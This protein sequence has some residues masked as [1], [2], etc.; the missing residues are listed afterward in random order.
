LSIIRSCGRGDYEA[1]YDTGVQ[2][3]NGSLEQRKAF[4]GLLEKWDVV[5]KELKEEQLKL[6]RNSRLVFLPDCGHNVQL[7]RPDVVASEIRW[8]MDSIQKSGIASL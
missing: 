4:K 6:S 2:A 3:G 1:I 7:L 5:D 8:V